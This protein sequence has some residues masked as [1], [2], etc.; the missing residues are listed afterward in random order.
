LLEHKAF[1]NVIVAGSVLAQVKEKSLPI[2]D[3]LRSLAGSSDRQYYVFA[4]DF[5]RYGLIED[6]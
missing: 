1:N 5:H 2:H 4:N 6:I 3:R